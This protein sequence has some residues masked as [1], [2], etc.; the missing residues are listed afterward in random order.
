MTYSV[1]MVSENFSSTSMDQC[2]QELE[3]DFYDQWH[4]QNLRE[5]EAQTKFKEQNSVV[6]NFIN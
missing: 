5:T 2:A 1:G 3:D 6:P 4:P